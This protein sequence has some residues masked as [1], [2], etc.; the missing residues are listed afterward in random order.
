[1]AMIGESIVPHNHLTGTIFDRHLI[2]RKIYNTL[3]KGRGYCEGSPGR[4]LAI[5]K[6]KK[7]R[8]P[9]RLRRIKQRVH[10]QQ[11]NEDASAYWA[12][13]FEGTGG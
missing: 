9:K 10:K 1:M 8:Q 4:T 3:L 6:P 7:K 5:M 2:G 12:R 11:T 13:L